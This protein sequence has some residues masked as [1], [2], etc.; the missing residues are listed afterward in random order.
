MLVD[1][2]ACLHMEFE[3]FWHPPPLDWIKINVDASLLESNIASIGCIIIDHEGRFLLAFGK[4]KIHW[5]I[6][7]L[8]MEAICLIREFLQ[9]WMFESEGV[10]I[11][12]DNLNIIKFLQDSMMKSRMITGMIENHLYQSSS[13]IHNV[14]D[15]AKSNIFLPT[16]GRKANKSKVLNVVN[17][18]LGFVKLGFRHNKYSGWG[19]AGF[20]IPIICS[21]IFYRLEVVVGRDDPV[22]ILKISCAKLENYIFLKPKDLLL[23]ST[24]REL[25]GEVELGREIGS[26]E[27]EF[28]RGFTKV[29]PSKDS[30]IVFL[31][32]PW[33]H[34]G[35][36]EMIISIRSMFSAY[37]GG[38][39]SSSREGRQQKIFPKIGKSSFKGGLKICPKSQLVD[40]YR[41][42]RSEH[43]PVRSVQIQLIQSGRLGSSG[44]SVEKVVHIVPYDTTIVLDD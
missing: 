17:D 25:R 44:R 42:G 8:E 13:M 4:K 2:G 33:F 36:R 30:I 22:I 9:T 20:H 32:N 5:D 34:G 43:R 7:Q 12:G 31:P 19:D 14:H 39:K 24:L 28:M 10:I 23:Y 21:F 37:L 16:S 3:N 6:N 35:Y 40:Q 11:E 18:H 38:S 41:P 26:Y 1:L 15:M 29:A 27:G